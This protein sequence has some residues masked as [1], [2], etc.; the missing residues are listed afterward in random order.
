MKK[1]SDSRSACFVFFSKRWRGGGKTGEF[2]SFLRFFFP[3]LSLKPSLFLSSHLVDAR[4]V[5]DGAVLSNPRVLVHDG[6]GDDAVGPDANGHA[7]RRDDLGALGRGLVVVRADQHRVADD[8]AGVDARAE[9]DDRV[10]DGAALEVA[11]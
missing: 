11:P 4:L 8:G 5:Q 3:L 9:A 2:L 1:P 7:S 6:I 10:V